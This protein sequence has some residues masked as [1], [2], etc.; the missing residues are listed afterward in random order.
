MVL[1]WKK[2][3]VTRENGLG[4]PLTNLAPDTHGAA[5]A[6]W[7]I[8]SLDLESRLTYKDGTQQYRAMLYS[9]KASGSSMCI[10]LISVRGY[11]PDAI[12]AVEELL[13]SKEYDLPP[14]AETVNAA[15][16]RR[17]EGHVYRIKTPYSGMLV[18]VPV[19]SDSG[20]CRVGISGMGGMK[21]DIQ[22]ELAR[23]CANLSM[24]GC[25]ISSVTEVHEHDNATPKVPVL[26]S[27]AYKAE[28]KRLMDAKKEV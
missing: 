7:G 11:L 22:E 21:S 28:I 4:Q 9:V 20:T 3:G 14:S 13:F 18:E 26:T 1:S 15:K 25:I 27:K 6:D 5:Y 19:G 10:P 12:K 8:F 2:G 17:V 24:N 16:A 23:Y